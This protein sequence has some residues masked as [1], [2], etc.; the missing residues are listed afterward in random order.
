MLTTSLHST[1]SSARGGANQVLTH[2]GTG[3]LS[4]HHSARSHDGGCW[5]CRYQMWQQGKLRFGKPVWF[6]EQCRTILRGQLELTLSSAQWAGLSL[7]APHPAAHFCTQKFRRWSTSPVAP[8][9]FLS[10]PD[11]H[12]AKWWNYTVHNSTATLLLKKKSGME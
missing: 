12:I 1:D 10:S 7:P 4:G 8:F 9:L 5:P 11:L 3:L 6:A 2:S